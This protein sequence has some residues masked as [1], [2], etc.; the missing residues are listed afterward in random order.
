MRRLELRTLLL[1][2]G[3]SA[4]AFADEESAPVERPDGSDAVA[5]EPQVGPIQPLVP[6]GVDYPGIIDLGPRLSLYVDHTYEYT[7]DLSTFWWVQGR[8]N[9]YRVALGGSYAFG[10]LRVH[11]E[12]PVQYTQLAIDLLMGNEPAATD[13]IKAAL[14]LGDVITDAAYYWDLPSDAMPTHV[15]LGLRV[16]WPT[17][18]TR[19]QFGLM[20]GG[21]I[22]FG[23]PYYLHLSPAAILSTSY[24]PVFLAGNQGMLAMLAKDIDLGGVLTKIPNMYFWESHVAAGLAATDWLAFT[25]EVLSVVQLNRVEMTNAMAT[26]PEEQT[27]V[28]PTRAV[29]FNPGAT[30]DLGRYRLALAARFGLPG[31]STRDFG[32]F[33]FSGTHAFLA[34]L[35]YL[36]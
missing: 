35:S 4:P 9:N 13:R 6:P 17:H 36:F 34:R 10:S 25:L 24:G 29:F 18:T 33:T 12:V 19:Y 26:T 21:T 7:N 30:L 16:R 1:L 2:L 15:G 20:N 3:L 5:A 28:F 23:I 8:G 31:N 27:R 32:V 22:E 14:S 11:A